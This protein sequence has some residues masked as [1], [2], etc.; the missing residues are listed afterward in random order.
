[1]DGDRFPGDQ[2]STE[3]RNQLVQARE[4]AIGAYDRALLTLSGGA[5]GLSLV[6]VNTLVGTDRPLWLWA[7][8]FSWFFWLSSL[9]MTLVSFYTSFCAL[10]KAIEDEDKAARGSPSPNEMHPGGWYSLCTY[11]LNLLSGVAFVMG[12]VSMLGFAIA[13]IIAENGL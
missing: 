4:K 1:M 5:L 3:Y 7:L 12:A 9:I 11:R 6:Y 10:E 8:I 2:E 13:N